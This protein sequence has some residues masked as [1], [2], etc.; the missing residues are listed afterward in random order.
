MKKKVCFMGLIL[1]FVVALAS[2][3]SAGETNKPDSAS[4]SEKKASGSNIGFNSAV[5]V[6]F[7]TAITTDGSNLYLTN[8]YNHTIQ[9]V[10]IST[11]E[12]STIAGLSG[13]TGES[14]GFGSG[15]LFNHP[16]G[17]TTDRTN[18]YI[19]D[20]GNCAIRKIVI[21]TGEV[22][23]LA[24]TAGKCGSADGAGA[25]AQ[26]VTPYG[27]TAAGT[28][29]YVVETES[30]SIR[31][32]DIPSRV[33]ATL[34][35][36]AKTK[37]SIDGREMAETFKHANAITTDGSNLYIV[38][39]VTKIIKKVVIASGEV[40]TVAGTR[41]VSGFADGMGPAAQ[42]GFSY[43]IAT[44][45]TNLYVADTYNAAI[46]KIALLTGEVSTLAGRAGSRGVIDGT[47]TTASF[48]MVAG[49]TLDGNNLYVVNNGN[50]AIRKVVIA[51]GAVTTLLTK[52]A[53]SV[54]PGAT[55]SSR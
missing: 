19:T 16:Q 24:G 47:G 44:D 29:L 51:S 4:T 26:F 9:K 55:D 11:G 50:S 3:G 2:N 14:D 10:S 5:H 35:V 48:N 32:I 6:N 43:G 37:S 42:F 20:T 28:S 27:I 52:N 15:A 30:G 12:V 7:A 39:N 1:A 45:G 38:D 46:R 22:S 49:I 41:G 54:H 18:L 33:V 8:T 34:A 13:V 53:V 17:I 25:M 40:T 21:S 31:K 36:S 23:T